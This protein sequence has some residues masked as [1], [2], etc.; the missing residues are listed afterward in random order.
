MAEYRKYSLKQNRFKRSFLAG[1]QVDEN[2]LLCK[3]TWYHRMF[4]SDGI[5]GVELGA[6]W[7]R[8]HIDWKLEKD[9]V[10]TVFVAATDIKTIWIDNKQY[11]LDELLHNSEVPVIQK[12]RVLEQLGAKKTINQ[13]DIL[14]YELEGRY[15]YILIEVYG[16]GNGTLYNMFVDNKADFFMDTFPEVYR[17]YGSF[18]HRYL[19]VFSSLYMD[20]QDRIDGVTQFLD[21]DTAPAELLP[22]FGQWMGLDVSGNFLSEKSLRLLVKEAYALNRIKGTKAA[23][24][25]VCEIVL[26]EKVIILEKNV[27]HMNT[28]AE[29]RHLYENLYG[30]GL[31]DVTLL[32]HT[33]VPENQKSQLMFLLNQFKPVRCR[34]KIKYLEPSGSLDGHVYMDMNACVGD[35]QAGVLDK[36][37]GLDGNILLKE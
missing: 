20:F 37:I 19:S 10:V 23:L 13:Q 3:E 36:R 6:L 16:I 29:N 25:R 33:Y 9:M 35:V 34:L 32:I 18:F 31:Y 11:H 28:Q 14:L 7:G 27:F 5:D 26:D 22:I 4:V 8:L 30:D 21:V 1:L 2:E 15:L 12:K 17:D 24:E